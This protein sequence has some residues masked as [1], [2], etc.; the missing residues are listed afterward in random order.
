MAVRGAAGLGKPVTDRI[1][2]RRQQN[3]PRLASVDRRAVAPP[4]RTY[5]AAGR[6][7]ERMG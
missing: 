3:R 1:F 4:G 6:S 2:Q 7:R 5:S